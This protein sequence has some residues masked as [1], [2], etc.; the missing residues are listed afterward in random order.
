MTG[1]AVDAAVDVEALALTTSGLSFSGGS[2]SSLYSCDSLRR[3]RDHHLWRRFSLF[4]IFRRRNTSRV[5]R[6]PR[7]LKVTT[8]PTAIRVGA[9][10]PPVPPSIPGVAILV[11]VG[12]MF[13]LESRVEEV[14]PPEPPPAPWSPPESPPTSACAEL[15]TTVSPFPVNEPSSSAFLSAPSMIPGMVELPPAPS[16]LDVVVDAV[17]GCWLAAFPTPSP[18]E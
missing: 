14:R 1:G 11:E 5:A 16:P 18:E 4:A 10:R 7:M 3:F 2:F 17:E 13:P 9:A 15:E 8:T 12:T 6:K